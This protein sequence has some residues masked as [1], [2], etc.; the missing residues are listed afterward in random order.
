[1]LLAFHLIAQILLNLVLYVFV[2][3]VE[4]FGGEG[5]GRG[6]LGGAAALFVLV[7]VAELGVGDEALF[8]LV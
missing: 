7:D 1:L 5:A 2:D 3:L 8:L 6:G 4:F